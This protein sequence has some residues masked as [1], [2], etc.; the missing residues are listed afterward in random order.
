[1]ICSTRLTARAF[2][3]NIP[4]LSVLAQEY[5]LM[6]GYG[7]SSTLSAQ[8]TGLYFFYNRLVTGD[9]GVAVSSNGGVSTST[10]TARTLLLDYV[11]FVGHINR[12]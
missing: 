2:R 4:T 7:I 6:M 11:D 5:T 12:S 10:T 1:M 8:T 3:A 9:F